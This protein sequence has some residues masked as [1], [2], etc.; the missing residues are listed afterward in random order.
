MSSVTKIPMRA[1]DAVHRRHYALWARDYD[2]SPNPLLALEERCLAP[3]LPSLTDADVVDVGCG[4]GRWLHRLADSAARSLTGIDFS[5]EMLERAKRKLGR[6]ARLAVGNATSLPIASRSTDIVVASFVASYVSDFAAF[7]SELR[8]VLRENGRIFLAD[9]H[10]ETELSCHWKRGFRAGSEQVRLATCSG[11][12]PQII[13]HFRD[14]GLRVSSLLEPPFG[15]PE[16]E[17]FRHA[18]KLGSFSAAAGLPAIYV[19]EL[20]MAESCTASVASDTHP[21]VLQRARIS[22]DAETSVVSDLAIHGR[23]I[24]AI[25]ST[26]VNNGD[27]TPANAVDLRGYLLLPGLINAHDHLE[28]GLY[29]R[30]GHPPYSNFIEWAT[31]IHRRDRTIITAQK[32]V[33]RDVQL[34]WG[35]IRNLLCGVTTV[36]HHNPVYPELLDDEFPLRVIKEFDWAHSLTIDPELGT[37]CRNSAPQR[38]FVTHAGEGVDERAEREIYAIDDLGALNERTV[39]VH[40]LA[41]GAEGIELLNRRSAA[42]VW[43]PSSNQ[44]LFGRTHN[45]EAIASIDRIL[46]GSDS[47]LTGA[48][49]LLEEVRLACQAGVPASDVYRMMFESPQN[50]FHLTNGEGRIRVGSSADFIAV[51]DSGLSPAVAVVNLNFSDVELVVVRGRVQVASDRIFRRLPSTLAEGLRPLQVESVLRWMRAPLGRLFREAERVLG[52]N[53]KVGGKR[54]RHVSSAW[55]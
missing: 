34:W 30:L 51:R 48:G 32:S 49:D 12:L 46:L 39:V 5:P 2:D 41:L 29:P 10:P 25:Q 18:G 13:A 42:L 17:T 15:P 47:P 37:K 8:R 55:L 31:D 11:T 6:R 21:V 7:A 14:E 24:G 20:R 4:T 52:C 28:F 36:C 43:C 26:S 19:L 45:R 9:V 44:F 50:V 16:L 35:A 23:R 3:L 33:P 27:A 40:G 22:L 53:I 38:P 1:T 54:M